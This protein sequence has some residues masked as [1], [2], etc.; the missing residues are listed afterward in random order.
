MPLDD[1]QVCAVRGIRHTIQLSLNGRSALVMGDNGTGKTSIVR[2][3]QWA[4]RGEHGPMQAAPA[5]E[6][7]FRGHVLEPQDKPFVRVCVTGG[8]SI[9][10][11][12]GSVVANDAGAAYREACIRSNSFLLRRQ[13][14]EILESRPIDRFRF[15]ESFLDVG[16]AD[17]VWASL[18]ARA[19]ELTR[20]VEEVGVRAAR[21]ISSVA[22]LLAPPPSDPIAGWDALATTLRD[23]AREL[24]AAVG[25]AAGWA[26]LVPAMDGLRQLAEPAALDARRVSL[27]TAQEVAREMTE[28]VSGGTA[29]AMLGLEAHRTALAATLTDATILDLLEHARRHFAAGAGSGRC[30]VCGNAVDRAALLGELE[31]RLG[32]MRELEQVR[33]QLRDAASE[34]ERRWGLFLGQCRRIAAGLGHRSLEEITGR[35]TPPP[36]A[37][38]LAQPQTADGASFL[39]RLLVSDP[40]AIEGWMVALSRFLGDHVRAAQAQLPPASAAPQ[41]RPLLAAFD[42]AVSEREHILGL[43][44]RTALGRRDAARLLSV[45][46]A[47][48]GAR[49][50]YARAKFD[51]IAEAVGRY[52]NAIHPP[53]AADEPTGPPTFALRRQREGTAFVRGS[54]NGAEVAD[55]RWVYS[56]GHLDTVGI[57]IFLALRRHAATDSR[58]PRLIVLDD[59][60]LS[61][62]LGHA[63][64][65][66]LLLRDEFRD[67]QVLFL[68]H[69]ELF[70]QWYERLVP[71]LARF[72]I[73]SWTLEDGPQIG[74]Y[75]NAIERLE[76]AVSH[77]TTPK[78]VGQAIQAAMDAWL[79]EARYVYQLAIPA[80]RG[81]RYAMG[82]LWNALCSALRRAYRALGRNGDQELPMLARLADLP[83][84]RNMLAAH[85]NE[86]AQQFPLTAIRA[87]ATDVLGLLRA[88]Y[89]TACCSYLEPVGDPRQPSLLQCRERHLCVLPVPRAGGRA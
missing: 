47:I 57:C 27:A 28:T 46:E 2:A 66:I 20:Q 58:D 55:P 87:V 52:Y 82:D 7:G 32:R 37:S 23:R 41:I 14:L 72:R 56:D 53:E 12:P 77:E 19:E 48:R 21:L 67:H 44:S 85:E 71:N 38:L 89:C 42:R 50:D 9:E 54:F 4:L 5:T 11:R 75:T 51:E 15:L 49:Q 16:Q 24:G 30:P 65:L 29:A 78:V 74:S 81:E 64:R 80:Q 18:S 36:S 84:I 8:G 6:E 79:H 88:L 22:A 76:R 13:L 63:R 35:P 43:E 25:A 61:I 62:D 10:V 70:A 33:A 39:A 17:Q 40:V 60:V 1:L 45:A 73:A 68:T 69:S 34:W 3:L 26:E 86:F 59:I 83:S 31:R